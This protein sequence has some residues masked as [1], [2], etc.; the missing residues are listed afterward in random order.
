MSVHNNRLMLVDPSIDSKGIAVETEP[1][2]TTTILKGIGKVREVNIKGA[3]YDV[4][5]NSA[6][7]WFIKTA[8]GREATEHTTALFK[9][10]M[11]S[12]RT[13][14][15]IFSCLG[16]ILSNHAT[17]LSTGYTPRP[18]NELF[19][20]LSVIIAGK[21]RVEIV[22]KLANAMISA[23]NAAGAASDA[24]SIATAAA[25]AAANAAA[26]AINMVA[27]NANANIA[28][29]VH[30]ATLAA[31]DAYVASGE[32]NTA[33]DIATEAAAVAKEATRIAADIND[34]D[35]AEIAANASAAI[36][37]ANTANAATVSADRAV[38]AINNAVHIASVNRVVQG[39][40]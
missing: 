34:A 15:D 30:N 11:L 16:T 13:T 26:N 9:E 38:H 1:G 7:G 40:G 10:A 33:A 18:L 25:T 23:A 28:D 19:E 36:A 4:N 20:L 29:L 6:V 17:L 35:A 21:D 22:E 3:N 5:V 24:A 39:G 12:F 8:S 27:H 14:E 31:M 37:A 32:A 2:I